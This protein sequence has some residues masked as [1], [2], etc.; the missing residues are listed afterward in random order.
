MTT[1]DVRINHVAEF[2]SPDAINSIET[3]RWMGDL[4]DE[5]KLCEIMMPGS[6]D[7]GMSVLQHC[8][9]PLVLDNY[10]RTQSLSVEGQL[11]AGARYFDIRIDYDHGELVTYHREGKWGCNGQSLRSILEQMKSF[12]TFYPT[13]F[14][15]LKF[16]HIRS[17]NDSINDNNAHNPTKTKKL[18]EEMLGGYQDFLYCNSSS[19]MNLVNMT[20]DTFRGKAILAFDYDEHISTAKGRF[21]YQNKQW[22]SRTN[23]LSVYD[24]YSNTYNYKT[25]MADQIN[26]WELHSKDR[27]G[28]L[29]LL[30]W[31]LTASPPQSYGIEVMAT[32]AKKNICNILSEGIVKRNWIKPNVVYIDFV[33]K[34]TCQTI[35]Q[36]NFPRFRPR[37]LKP[38][39]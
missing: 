5:L 1:K 35:I 15:I 26:K 32:A 23:N 21:R 11:Y 12:L 19:T 31:T 34:S 7:A 38:E 33:D 4:Y 20:I 36:F 3:E 22:T 18:I 28:Y 37:D 27:N 30:S 24:V 25:M 17:F 8:T 14:L 13:E 2:C 16:S 29:F 9:L 6:H 39:V 10:T